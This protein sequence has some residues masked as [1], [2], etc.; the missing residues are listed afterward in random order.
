[1]PL[2]SN[3]LL[4]EM[5]YLQASLNF[6][7]AVQKITSAGFFPILAHPERYRY[8][9]HKRVIIQGLQEKKCAI[10]TKFVIHK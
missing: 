5:S 6:E 10:S 1:M 9:H 7:D 4:I 8:L 3:H 2:R